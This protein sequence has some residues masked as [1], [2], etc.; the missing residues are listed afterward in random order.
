MKIKLTQYS[1]NSWFADCLD[2]AGSPPVGVGDTKEEAIACLWRDLYQCKM[3]DQ[4]NYLEP[5]EIEEDLL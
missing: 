4:V 3:I 1:T 5:I 2:V